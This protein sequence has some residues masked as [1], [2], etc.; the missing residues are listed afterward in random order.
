MSEKKFS[1]ICFSGDF[2][3]AVAAFTLAAGAAA[4]NYE[5]NVFFTFWGLNILKKNAGRSLMGKGALARFFNFLMGGPK[6]LPL[7]RLNFG[8]ISPGLM[9]GMMKKRNVATLEELIDSSKAL[10]VRLIACE[11]AMHILGI[12]KED[13]IDDVKEVIGVPTFLD[14]SKDGQMVFIS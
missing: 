12:A 10:G 1:I 3:K 6:N 9:T 14:Y 8:G 7:S 13:L 2:D 11:M 4:V 5:V